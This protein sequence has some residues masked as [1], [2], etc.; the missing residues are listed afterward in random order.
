MLLG[1]VTHDFAPDKRLEVTAYA[2]HYSLDLFTDFTYFLQCCPDQPPPINPK[3]PGDGFNQSDDRIYAGSNATYQQSLDLAMPTVLTFGLDQRSDF[4]GVVLAHAFHRDRLGYVADDRIHETSIAGFGQADVLVAPWV[5]FIPGLRVQ[6]F[7]FDVHNHRVN[8]TGDRPSGSE[9]DA[10][11]LPKANLIVAP[12]SEGGPLQSSFQPLRDSQLFLNWG[13]GFH[14][15]DARDV[16][17]N[18]HGTTL[19]IAM[20]WEIGWHTPIAHMLDLSLDYWWLNLQNEFVFEGDSGT[21]DVQGRSRRH[22][23]EVAARL[24]PWKWLY[25]EGAVNYSSAE[26]ANGGH[27]PQSPRL[28]AKALIR[29]ISP[30][31]VTAEFD[32]AALGTRYAEEDTNRKLSNYNVW[33]FAVR[34]RRGAWEGNVSVENLFDTK[35]RNSEFF[36]TSRLPNEPP[37]GVDDFHFT[38]GD[39]R[40]VRVALRYYF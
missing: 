5:H 20:G 27:V 10:V 15:N 32:Y 11:P 4:P 14:S 39:P 30:W 38:P 12:F 34:Y 28:I 19:P 1:R 7:F 25:A 40:N 29:F 17:A 26:F 3:Q 23:V 33:N 2:V 16:V 24:T 21:T 18:P 36:Y 31:G 22:G 37:Q 35:W 6:A 13:E 9:S 8:Q